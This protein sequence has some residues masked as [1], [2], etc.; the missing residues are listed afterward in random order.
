DKNVEFFAGD[1]YKRLRIIDIDEKTKSIH[2]ICE[3]GKITWPL[4]FEKLEEIHKIIHGGEVALIPYKID[5]LI[6]T[7]GNFVTGLFKYLSCGKTE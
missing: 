2:M 1:G 4:R 3:L 5:K 6:P 7:W